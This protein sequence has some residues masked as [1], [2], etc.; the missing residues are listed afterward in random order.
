MCYRRSINS[1]I[2]LILMTML[3]VMGISITGL[4]GDTSVRISSVRITVSDYLKN[5][6]LDGNE[7]IPS[8]SESDFTVPDN[9]Q[10]EISN[11]TWLGGDSVNIG[12][13]PNVEIYLT[14]MEKERSN[15]YYTYYYFSGT[16]DRTNVHV[17]GGDFV[18][19]RIE[20]N[21]AL[22]VVIAL[23][24]IKGTYQS[25]VSPAWSN[26]TLGLALWSAPASTSGYYKV[27]LFKDGIKTANLI[28]DQT[29]LNLYPYMTRTG[30]YHFEVSTIP[31]TTAQKNGKE[32]TAVTS[33]DINISEGET[34][35]GNGQYTDSKYLLNSNNVLN[36][37]QLTGDTT[38][39]IASVND[40]TLAANYT[41]YNSNN[42]QTTTLPGYEHRSS[43][44]GTATANSTSYTTGSWY[45]EGNY[46]YFRTSDGSKVC[47]DWLM[48]KNAYYRFDADGKML[49]GF[50]HKDDYSTYYLANS[51]ALK[52]GWVL[53][54]NAWYYMN[55]QVGEYYGLMYKNAVVNIGD[56][57][58]Y[59]DADGKMRTGWVIIKDA[60]GIDQ[61]Y[62]FYP[63][64]AENGNNYGHMAKGT[65]IL[66]GLTIAQDGHWVH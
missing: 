6:E 62:Y 52:T 64:T 31:Y 39:N 29:S 21:Y 4:A 41:V 9:N 2:Y 58:Y 17:S 45:K 11:V 53:I 35:D 15:D 57:S 49:T 54:N 33:S 42:G 22:R 24:G 43:A 48:W 46:W 36:G 7:Q 3:F 25:P 32:S 8:L 18:S 50:Y 23:K 5:I 30:S 26:S 12:A 20:G 38:G 10:Y 47:S 16:Y 28:S 55:P 1:G 13:T 37:A 44:N 40:Y 61:Y 65:T 19:A 60:D 14:S 63:K 34:S 59:F 56:K 51:G 66:D 27:S